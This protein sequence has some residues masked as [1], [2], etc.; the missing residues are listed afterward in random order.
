MSWKMLPAVLGLLLPAA[1]LSAA[2]PGVN[3][4]VIFVT[5]VYRHYVKAQSTHGDYTPSESIFT[6]RL[7]KLVQDDRKRAKGEVGCL[8]F[9]FWV[10]GQDWTI[11]KVDVKSGTKSE[12]RWEVIATFVNLGSPEEIHFDFQR[13]NGG[14]L[15]D[16]VR[17][18]KGQRWILSAILKC[19]P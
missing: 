6:A 10:N 15:L 13:I 19:T 17:S 18:V 2:P 11:T 12:D 8:D 5:D 3:D 16:D 9:D 1:Q 4:P 14:W 7:R